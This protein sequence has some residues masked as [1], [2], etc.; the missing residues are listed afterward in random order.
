MNKIRRDVGIVVEFK[1]GANM[2]RLAKKHKLKSA[3]IERIVRNWLNDIVIAATRKYK[4]ESI[5]KYGLPWVRVTK[6]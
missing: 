5:T 3:T 6:R 4:T 2:S 1:R